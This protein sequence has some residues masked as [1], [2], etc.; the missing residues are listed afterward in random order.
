M[1][2]R[3][4]GWAV[5]SC[6][7]AVAAT[8]QRPALNDTTMP[9]IQ[10]AWQCSQARFWSGTQYWRD[11][12]LDTVAY[13]RAGLRQPQVVTDQVRRCLARLS[14]ET[15]PVRDLLALVEAHV[16]AE[17]YAL[18]DSA[19]TRLLREAGATPEGR[20]D[21]L[22]QMV[23]ALAGASV[24]QLT[25]AERYRAE[26]EAMGASAALG[27]MDAALVVAQVAQMEGS[28]ALWG[29][30]I[31]SA[32]TASRQLTDSQRR[33]RVNTIA[34]VAL[35]YADWRVRV[36][37]AP[38][39]LRAFD[40]LRAEVVPIRP[41]M[42]RTISGEFL[43]RFLPLGRTVS[44]VRAT[45]W[46][47]NS[48][49]VYPRRGH[50]TLLVFVDQSCGADCYPGYAMLR[51][52]RAR[53]E[54]RGLDLVLLARTFGYFRNKLETPEDEM[55]L[56]ANYFATQVGLPV[57]IALWR[58]SMIRLPDGRV[59]SPDDAYPNEAMIGVKPGQ[60][61]FAVLVMPDGVVRFTA[62]L[63]RGNES[64]LSDVI[65]EAVAR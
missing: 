32:R 55:R 1:S 64:V 38:G 7:F 53:Y 51:R 52:L 23:R 26:L 8:A 3:F 43:P 36:G 60:R 39:A 21:V 13:P 28:L 4:F 10:T 22:E 41:S 11:K 25:R 14:L 16:A 44:A 40:A 33:E 63:N 30:A 54:A 19:G 47:N 18:A 5:L 27:R 17:Q 20:A 15:V 58:P 37:D 31:A 42:E 34:M 46:F 6:G 35:V 49:P 48:A 9:R 62:W 12:R 59:V 65:A 57:P 2:I 50:A 56:T 45:R 29:N 61:N 24:P